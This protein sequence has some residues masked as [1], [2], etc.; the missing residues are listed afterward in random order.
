M[1]KHSS[2]DAIVIG[3]GISG[4]ATASLLASRGWRVRLFE[5]QPVLGGRAAVLKKDGFSFDMGPSWYLMPEVFESFFQLFGKS[6]SDYYD[7]IRLDPRYRVYFSDGSVV[8]LNDSLEQNKEVFDAMIPGSGS[9]LIAYLEQK[10]QVYESVVRLIWQNIFSWKFFLNAKNIR[11]IGTFLRAFSLKSWHDEAY[12]YFRD[13]RLAKIMTFPSVFLGGSPYATP[14]FYSIL[15]WADFGQGVWYPKGGIG[16]IIS[17]LEQLA[18]SFG[19]E[20]HTG[21]EAKH[22]HVKDGRVSGVSVGD[23]VYDASVVVG[24]CDLHH[25]ETQLLPKDYQ[26]WDEQWWRKKTIGIS[27]L[28]VYL[29]IQKRLKHFVHHT[30]YFSSDWKNNFSDIFDRR[31]IPSDPSFYV[32][33]RSVTDRSIVPKDADELFLLI[34]LGARGDYASSELAALADAV[35]EKIE[36][37]SGESFSRHIRVKELFGPD[38]FQERYHAYGGT[39]LGFAHT[40][41]QSLWLRPRNKSKK[42]HGLYYAGQYVQPGVGVPMTLISAKLVAD[43][44]G[45]PASNKQGIFQ[46]GSVTYYYSSIFFRGQ[47]KEDVFALYAYVRTVDDLIDCPT[48]DTDAFESLWKETR[49]CWKS[50]TTEHQTVR[51]FIALAKRKTF[52]WKWI[53]AF[54]KSMRSD[55]TKRSYMKFSELESY[56]YGSAEVVGLMMAR[57]LDLPES[58]NETARLQ[59]KAM[60]YVNFIRDVAEDERL[61]R[62]YLGYTEEMRRDPKR[63]SAFLRAHIEKYKHIQRQAEKGFAFIP[64]QY[65]PP[66]QAA[67]ALYEKTADAIYADPMIVWKKKVKPAKIRVVAE[68]LRQFIS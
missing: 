48:P 21:E 60:Q 9:N 64:K 56:M 68:V 10:R 19:V 17:S 57:I 51:E 7:L 62:N 3:G 25:L 13:D 47:V 61:G 38:Q 16:M 30:L 44:I 63:W 27:A 37:F 36:S 29:G 50:G 59:G 1:A 33:A 40:W 14:S 55:L 67:A 49:L 32:S 66:I 11:D 22:I 45:S 52:D 65:R 20:I 42:V 34:P 12:A 24:A 31:S 26:S 4:L 39:A 54:W 58:A 28:L 43:Q 46:R 18:R 2:S 35:I 15:S 23:R 5:K 41:T 53:E 6:S 8:T